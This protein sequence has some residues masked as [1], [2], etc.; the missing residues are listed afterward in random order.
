MTELKIGD[1]VAV[2]LEVP[3]SSWHKVEGYVIEERAYKDSAKVR[4]TKAPNCPSHVGRELTLYNLTK[5]PQTKFKVGDRVTVKGWEDKSEISTW[6]GRTGEVYLVDE[7]DDIVCLK[8][9]DGKA[10]YSGGWESKH[11]VP[12]EPE[13]KFKVGDWVKVHGRNDRWN[14]TVGTVQ[15]V[16]TNRYIKTCY[17]IHKNDVGDEKPQ[18][19]SKNVLHFFEYQLEAT[20]APKPERTLPG[21]FKPGDVVVGVKTHRNGQVMTVAPWEQQRKGSGYIYTLVRGERPGHTA[22]MLPEEIERYG[23]FSY[24]ELKGYAAADVKAT[25]NLFAKGGL[26]SKPEAVDG[27]AH[28]GGKDNP[29]EVIKV[30]EAWGFEKNAYLFNALKY[31]GRAGKKG[32][33]VEDLK[34]LKFYVDREIALEEAK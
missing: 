1:K 12:A 5:L 17:T 8:F 18:D 9:E 30:A 7:T 11:L 34:K 31:L 33:K 28:Y 22:L 32:S 3:S 21:G 26:V 2:D 27:P 20:E 25:A 14:G 16:D 23:Y 4:V 6:E 13:P 19:F 29:Y 15:K 10:P 24:A